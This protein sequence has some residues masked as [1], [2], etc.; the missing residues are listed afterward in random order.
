MSGPY[1]SSLEHRPL[2]RN[3]ELYLKQLSN[4][5]HTIQIRITFF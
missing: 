4:V 3:E 1:F 2:N 5:R